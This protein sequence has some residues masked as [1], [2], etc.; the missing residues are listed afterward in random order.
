M[1][2]TITFA[3]GR[4]FNSTAA[5]IELAINQAR[6]HLEGAYL[7]DSSQAPWIDGPADEI[8]AV[9]LKG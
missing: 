9:A 7:N 4:T 8:T 2:Y 6:D 1:T 5:D 3:S